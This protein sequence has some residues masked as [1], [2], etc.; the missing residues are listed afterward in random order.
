MRELVTMPDAEI[1]RE[2][3]VWTARLMLA[4]FLVA[5]VLLGKRT[6]SFAQSLACR[7]C[8]FMMAL[9]LAA[10]TT[11]ASLNKEPPLSFGSPLE[12]IVSFGGAGAAL[13]LVIGALAW[14]QPWYR[15]LQYWPWGVFFFTT[16]S[17]R[18]TVNKRRASPLRLTS[19]G[20]LWQPC[21]WHCAGERGL[22]GEHHG[23][24]S[25]MRGR[26]NN[27]LELQQVNPPL[28]RVVQTFVI[29]ARVADE[30]IVFK[31]LRAS[32]VLT[33]DCGRENY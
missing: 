24:I 20:Q 1:M 17:F 21:S 14:A 30:E 6:A 2:L 8:G 23:L 18:N 32:A 22:T 4:V 9:H 27:Q 12:L 31:H 10:L 28:I 19:L 16:C 26:L 5:F 7:I 3:S 33:S 13:V 11:L 25:W 29:E 15:W